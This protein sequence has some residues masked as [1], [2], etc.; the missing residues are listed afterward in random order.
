MDVEL[1]EGGSKVSGKENGQHGA[2]LCVHPRGS[3]MVKNG[4]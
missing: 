4:T 1:Q 2:M 3:A